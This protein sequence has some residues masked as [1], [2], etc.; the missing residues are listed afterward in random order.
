RRW[1]YESGRVGRCQ[2]KLAEAPLQNTAAGLS[3]FKAQ[4]PNRAAMAL[5]PGSPVAVGG[6][7]ILPSLL[8]QA[9]S[10]DSDIA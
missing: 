5:L 3:G 7:P 1:Y 2:L 8:N 6:N 10:L 9:I 4:P